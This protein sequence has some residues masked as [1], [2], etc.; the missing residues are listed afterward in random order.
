MKSELHI[1]AQ[2]V[3]QICAKHAVYLE[4]QWL[5]R[6]E[7][8]K[9]DFLSRLI[10]DWEITIDCFKVINKLWGPHTLDCFA[11]FYNKKINKYFSRFWNPGTSGVDFFVQKIQGENCLVVPPVCS[12]IRA[13]HYLFVCKASATVIVPFW[14]SAIFWPV[15][16]RT[17]LSFIKGYR[18]FNGRTS[19]KQGK[20]KNS[21]FGS[22]RF[23]GDILAIRFVYQD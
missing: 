22:D 11:N 14:P 23:F 16:S 7:L 6:S 4:I 9:A 19:L 17:Y 8:E 15:I 3:F 10:D 12:V 5:P 21:L 2:N 13:L 1:I 18:L 20:N